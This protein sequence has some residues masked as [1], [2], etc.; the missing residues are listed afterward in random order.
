M[1]YSQQYDNYQT[2]SQMR[3]RHEKEDSTPTAVNSFVLKHQQPKY[4]PHANN[5]NPNG[6]YQQT[7]QSRYHGNGPPPITSSHKQ[8]I[9]QNKRNHNHNH[10]HYHHYHNHHQHSGS[11][12]HRS[13]PQSQA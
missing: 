12:L 1:A 10:N 4:Q 8:H 7:S 3:S 11:S 9:K 13:Q 5:Q 2:P 6:Y